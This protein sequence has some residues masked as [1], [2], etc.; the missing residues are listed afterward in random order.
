MKIKALIVDL[1]GTILNTIVTI[2]YFVNKTFQ[3]YGISPI[4]EQECKIFIGNG[5]RKLILRAL[6]SKSIEIIADSKCGI[7]EKSDRTACD[8]N[9]NVSHASGKNGLEEAFTKAI[10]EDQMQAILDDYNFAYDSDP[11]YLTEKYDGLDVLFKEL[12]E[13]GI[14]LAVISNKPHSTA[15]A[16]AEHFYP[17][18]FDIAFGGREGVPLKPDPTAIQSVLDAL[19]I[20]SSEI[21]YLGDSD[22]DMLFGKACGSAYTLGAA[23][24]FRGRAELEA[25][26]ADK[27]FDTPDELLVFLKNII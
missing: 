13:H 7:A 22:V 15:K 9:I 16:A 27:V 25:A 5:A 12:S 20:S 23:W 10:T 17:N 4:T 8:T 6:A 26:G 18:V 24:G 21:A 2:T 3:K 1:D 14:K 19:G 11:Y